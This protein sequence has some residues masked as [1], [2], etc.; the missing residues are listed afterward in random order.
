MQTMHALRQGRH[1]NHLS[2]L[3]VLTQ[4]PAQLLSW[5]AAMLLAQHGSQPTVVLLLEHVLRQ[6]LHIT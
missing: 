1:I 6:E 4:Y 3:A 2:L 5:A